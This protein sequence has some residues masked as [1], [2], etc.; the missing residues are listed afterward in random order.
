MEGT[1]DLEKI[2]T[3]AQRMELKFGKVEFSDKRGNRVTGFENDV[4]SGSKKSKINISKYSRH[5]EQI[6][7]LNSG[8]LGE[9]EVQSVQTTKTR[10][11]YKKS[12]KKERRS[13]SPPATPSI[14]SS[15]STVK[16]GDK[17]GELILIKKKPLL[18]PYD[19]YAQF[20]FSPEN[21]LESFPSLG[22]LVFDI[23]PKEL[24]LE[25]LNFSF[26]WTVRYLSLEEVCLKVRGYA[27]P[28]D[29]S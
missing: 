6:E 16:G 15:Q 9:P 11:K 28:F 22:K 4:V 12:S 24:F 3:D 1:I 26:D 25:T 27:N 14:T 20:Q 23:I 5:Q 21:Y 7:E 17:K 29:N 13:L 2:G 8:K 18:N 19:P 10:K